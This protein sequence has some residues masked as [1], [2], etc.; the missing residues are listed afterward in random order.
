VLASA[1][2]LLIFGVAAFA[3]GSGFLAVYLAGIVMGNSRLVFQRGIFLFH[4]A[5]AWFAQIIMFIVLG[6]LSF[7]SRL[8]DAAPEGLLVAAVLFFVARPVAV[9]AALFP[10][11][12]S[13]REFVFISWVGLKGAVPITLATFPLL[14]QIEGAAEM[15]DIVFFVVVVSA[16]VQGWSM[17]P[18]ARWLGVNQPL[19]PTPPV[20]LEISSLRHVDGDIV[21]FTVAH[22]S[23][24]AGRLVREL[25]LPEG[26]VIAM[27]TRGQKII[28]PHGKTLIEP[29]DHVIVV[30]RP[31]TRPLVNNIFARGAIDREELPPEMDFPLRANVTVGELEAFY[32]ISMEAPPQTTLNEYLCSRLEG[33]ALRVGA[34]VVCGQIAL[35][36][37]GMSELGTIDRVGMMILPHRE[38]PVADEPAPP[39]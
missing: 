15:F 27:I 9:A 17:P 11:R 29:G 16:L 22:D 24:A 3:E 19:A 37:R 35:S 34:S 2:G 39:E 1:C 33:E 38:P 7:P 14:F 13:L 5:G 10:F 25:A 21:D 28:P 6:M 12:F 30:L 20:T 32:G 4:D 23:R 18:V 26:V 36:I 8:L 31:E